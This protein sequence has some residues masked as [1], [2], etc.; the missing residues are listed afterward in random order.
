MLVRLEAQFLPVADGIIAGGLALTVGLGPHEVDDGAGA[1][2]DSLLGCSHGVR[3]VVARN[4][5]AHVADEPAVSQAV[6]QHDG[7]AESQALILSERVG[8]LN[9]KSYIATLKAETAK[10]GSPVRL[11]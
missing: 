3:L 7:I 9:E 1:G 2:A 8:N 10:S 6:A 11:N 5:V 4:P